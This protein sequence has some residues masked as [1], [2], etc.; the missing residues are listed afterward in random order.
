VYWRKQLETQRQQ[1]EIEYVPSYQAIE[2]YLWLGEKET[3]LQ[4]LE[5][6]YD[7]RSDAPLNVRTEP[8]FDVLR[9]DSRFQHLLRRSG[10]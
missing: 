3:A 8:P 4:L 2:I 6:N 5:K 10:L 7:E 1:N 9:N